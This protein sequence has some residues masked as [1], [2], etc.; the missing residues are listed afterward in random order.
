MSEQEIALSQWPPR[1]EALL[2]SFADDASQGVSA[3]LEAYARALLERDWATCDRLAGEPFPLPPEIAGLVAA[4]LQP[5]ARALQDGRTD[6]G[7]ALIAPHDDDAGAVLRAALGDAG[8]GAAVIGAYEAPIHHLEGLWLEAAGRVPH[9]ALAFCEAGKRYAWEGEPHRDV[10]LRLLDRASALDPGHAPTHW[11]LADEWLNRSFAPD[12]PYVDG[13]ALARSLD[14]WNRGVALQAPD[15]STSWV[16]VTRALIDEQLARQDCARER[17]LWWQAIVHLE[18]ALVLEDW[19]AGRLALLGRFHHWLEHDSCALHATE[20]ALAVDDDDATALESRAAV[21]ADRGANEA[22]MKA[23]DR[24]LEQDESN[25]WARSVKAYILMRQKDYWSARRL[26][27]DVL[28]VDPKPLWSRE[29]LALCCRMTGDADAARAAYEQ[30]WAAHGRAGLTDDDRRICAAAAFRLGKLDEANAL[31][32]ELARDPLCPPDTQGLRGLC[33][34]ACGDT[35]GG[36]ALLRA[37]VARAGVPWLEEFIF[38]DAAELLKQPPDWLA[39]AP[40]RTSFFCDVVG[41]AM[42]RLAELRRPGDV[43]LPEAARAELLELLKSAD[44]GGDAAPAI[45]TAVQAGLARLHLEARRWPEAVESYRALEA[46]E[47]GFAEAA[48]GIDKAIDGLRGETERLLADRESAAAAASSRR[49]LAVLQSL[50]RQDE[51]L[52]ALRMLGDALWLDGSDAQALEN[53]EDALARAAPRDAAERAELHARIAIVRLVQGEIAGARSA[54]VHALQGFGEA[55]ASGAGPALGHAAR[56]QIRDVAHFW[57]VHTHWSALEADATLERALRQG[58]AAARAVLADYLTQAF[59]LADDAGSS[60]RL[61]VATPIGLRV[62]SDLVPR[63]DPR[64]DNGQFIEKDIPEMR[65]RIEGD[66][67]MRVPHVRVREDA[68]LGAGGYVI[69]VDEVPVARGAVQTGSLFCSAPRDALESAGVAGDDVVPAPGEAARP[70]AAGH[71][72][73]ARHAAALTAHGLEPLSETGYILAHAQWVLRHHLD[74]FLGVEEVEELLARAPD[75]APEDE[76]ISSFLADD[77]ARLRFARVLRAL[78]R[79]QVPVTDWHA[80]AQALRASPAGTLGD[81]VRH[82]RQA[83]RERLPAN[84]EATTLVLLPRAWEERLLPEAPHVSPDSAHRL[85]VDVRRWLATRAPAV[86]LVTREASLRPIVRRLVE[87]EFP[88]VAVLALDEVVQP[89]RVVPA[90]GDAA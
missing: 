8:D 61:P 29:I 60:L 72:C 27:E 43:D 3:W 90:D 87:Y 14:A 22:A 28:A 64:S 69:L 65:E 49:L 77:A 80:I 4:R 1:R 54:F 85:V 89:E 68:A 39:D 11:H 26:I 13:A 81:A 41:A 52:G 67:G 74:R 6:E 55:G 37:T 46:P 78:V 63:V 48:A 66:M 9:A 19:E 40:A 33:R 2:R 82:V 70:G 15:A 38:V 16:Y 17:A 47:S 62:A 83:L 51:M 88:G 18:R 86:A 53:Y 84:R 42:S 34:F 57:S 44:G 79:E 45:R 20:Q 59:H 21:L 50:A 5:G 31:L 23:I 32:D 30:I 24:R 75:G 58:F 56:G 12:P 76:A 25:A 36:E 7:L 10:S 73:A 35:A 71:W